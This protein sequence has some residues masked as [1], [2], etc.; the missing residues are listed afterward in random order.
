MYEI[1]PK[2]SEYNL[3]VLNIFMKEEIKYVF[4]YP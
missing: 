1:L 2:A 3:V 4:K